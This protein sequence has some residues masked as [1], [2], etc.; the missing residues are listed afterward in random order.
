MNNIGYENSCEEISLSCKSS[1]PHNGFYKVGVQFLIQNALQNDFCNI[2]ITYLKFAY[3][4]K[5]FF[6]IQSI[7]AF[8]ECNKKSASISMFP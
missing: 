7:V 4:Q 6:I 8:Y 2:F 3:I 1:F 5:Q